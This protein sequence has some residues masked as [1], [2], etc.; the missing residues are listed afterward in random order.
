[1]NTSNVDINIHTEDIEWRI[2]ITRDVLAITRRVE[3]IKKK[4]SAAIAFNLE[5]KAFIVYIANFNIS[6]NIGN[7]VH[8]SRRT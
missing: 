4:E 2:Y 6:F 3:Q 1:M 5:Y 8:P 7:I